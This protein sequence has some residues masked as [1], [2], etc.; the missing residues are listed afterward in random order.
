MLIGILQCGHLPDDIQAVHGDYD[1]VYARLLEGRGYEFRA[2]SV[3]D[4]DFPDGPEDADAWLVTGS[5][6]GAYEDLPFIAPLEELIRAIRD[7]GKPLVGICFGHQII[8]QALGGT[9][10]K[11]AGGWGTGLQTYA[12]DGHTLD[13]MAWHQDQVTRVPK[14]AQVIG[15]SEFCENAFVSY[16]PKTLTMQPHPEFDSDLTARLI[17]ARR[18]TVPTE[19][20]DQAS[21][22]LDMPIDQLRAADMIAATFEGRA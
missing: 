14:E 22:T 9:V 1:R 3:V 17:E 5:K 12:V 16:G 19:R 6:Y 2:W 20:L 10:E 15:R 21:R 18:G 4:M 7:A 13:L 11:F 8:A